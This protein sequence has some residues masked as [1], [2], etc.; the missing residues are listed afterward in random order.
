VSRVDPIHGRPIALLL[1]EP[2]LLWVALWDGWS[3]A[4]M[5]RRGG[6]MRLLP[7]PVPRPTG[8]GWGGPDGGTLFVTSARHGLVPQQIAEAPA[9]GS[10]FALDA[11]TRAALLR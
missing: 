5:T 7:L 1:E 2:D 11:G 9:S 4:R 6:D 8:L 10:V 3:L